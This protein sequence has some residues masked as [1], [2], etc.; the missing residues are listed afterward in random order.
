MK[1]IRLGFATRRKLASYWR[2]LLMAPSMPPLDPLGPLGPGKPF[3]P[4]APM[5]PFW[6]VSPEGPL[7]PVSPLSSCRM[8]L[9]SSSC[10]AER[11]YY[12]SKTIIPVLTLLLDYLLMLFLTDH[13]QLPMD[14]GCISHIT[15]LPG[16]PFS[17]IVP[18]KP[19]LPGTPFTPSFPFIAHVSSWQR[20][21][22][23]STQRKASK[24]SGGILKYLRQITKNKWG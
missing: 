21:K 23:S 13:F 11:T 7:A 19:S 4:C 15:F 1:L 10:N 5:K 6:P 8:I 12:C 22:G 17:P 2:Y 9:F 16:A 3:G 18:G 20:A 24:A 14:M